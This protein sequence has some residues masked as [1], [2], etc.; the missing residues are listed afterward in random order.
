MS[1]SGNVIKRHSAKCSDDVKPSWKYNRETCQTTNFTKNKTNSIYTVTQIFISI[2]LKQTP[3][4]NAR[5]QIQG[6]RIVWCACLRHSFCW[7]SLLLLMKGWPGWVNLSMRIALLT[8]LLHV[9]W[10]VCCCCCWCN[11]PSQALPIWM[12]KADA[13]KRRNLS[14][15]KVSPG[16]HLSLVNLTAI[17]LN[18]GTTQG[19]LS[20]PT[21]NKLAGVVGCRSC[22]KVVAGKRWQLTCC[23]KLHWFSVSGSSNFDDEVTAYSRPCVSTLVSWGGPRGDIRQSA[24]LH[25]MIYLYI[26][27]AY[28]KWQLM[29]A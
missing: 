7:H 1:T 26:C 18:G 4:Y 28:I 11:E 9:K 5:P 19:Q 22:C 6:W 29:Y 15:F 16:F 20:L 23:V 27:V 13:P 2:A 8:E 14:Y 24:V 12:G 17:S 25:T 10:L 21:A 3:A